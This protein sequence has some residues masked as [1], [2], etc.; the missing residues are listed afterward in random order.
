MVMDTNSATRQRLNRLGVIWSLCENAGH[1]GGDCF[2]LFDFLV[3]SKGRLIGLQVTSRGNLS[4]HRATFRSPA[5]APN[6]KA[7]RLREATEAWLRIG[8]HIELWGWEKKGGKMLLLAEKVV[9]D[10]KADDV[11]QFVELID[12]FKT[13][14][15]L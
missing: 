13:G 7:Y 6:R 14:R 4:S 15:V 9:L 12:E 3:M 1:H 5:F 11:I 2:G 8:L 10:Y